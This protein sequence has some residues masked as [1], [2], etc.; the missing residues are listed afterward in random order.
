MALMHQTSLR[1]GDS[2]VCLQ[3]LQCFAVQGAVRHRVGPERVRSKAYARRLP[4]T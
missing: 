2:I 1:V 3:A 4:E